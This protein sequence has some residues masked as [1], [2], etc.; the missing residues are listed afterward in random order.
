MTN[1]SL[2]SITE[3]LAERWKAGTLPGLM[4]T[5]TLLLEED[6]SLETITVQ[7]YL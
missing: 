7:L 3:S 5:S 4:V 2:G 1:S 6:T